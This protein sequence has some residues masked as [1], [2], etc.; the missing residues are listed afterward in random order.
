MGR[1]VRT[2]T[3]SA[4]E[5][6]HLRGAAP[7]ARLLPPPGR[8]PPLG[9]PATPADGLPLDPRPTA[10]GAHDSHYDRSARL[11]LSERTTR[12]TCTSCVRTSDR[13]APSVGTCGV[14][15]GFPVCD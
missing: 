3:A 9:R 13:A 12:T 2:G 8:P 5:S 10:A 11:A 14:R 6:R 1:P 4:E 15:P 7:A